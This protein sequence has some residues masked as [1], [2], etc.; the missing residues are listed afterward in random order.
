MKTNRLSQ[1]EGY[2]VEGK[3]FIALVADELR[4]DNLR[5]ALRITRA[6]LHALRDRLQPDDAVQFGQGLPMLIKGIYFDQYD[7]S[8]TPVVIRHAPEF[9]YFIHEK[10]VYGKY[11]DFAN[12]NEIM[13]ALQGVFR[14][15]EGKMDYGQVRQIKYLLP[16]EIQE[17]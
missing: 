6:V 3:N 17:M 8:D 10:N 7:I 4:T 16:L 11:S 9:L 2:A 12:E 14:V 15:L 13:D 1:F 5:K